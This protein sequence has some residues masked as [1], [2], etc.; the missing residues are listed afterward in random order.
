M[1][2]YTSPLTLSSA[3]NIYSFKNSPTSV[4]Q[5]DKKYRA[6]AR[7]YHPDKLSG[8]WGGELSE[9]NSGEE[10][11]LVKESYGIIKGYILNGDVSNE[12]SRIESFDACM[13]SALLSAVAKKDSNTC[14]AL[15][16]RLANDTLDTGVP[17]K[18]KKRRRE[19]LRIRRERRKG[20]IERWGGEGKVECFFGGGVRK[21]ERSVF[22]D[23]WNLGR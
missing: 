16:S 6:L 20:R 13:L 14:G 21:S 7:K 18:V 5:L 15:G 2:K 1:S 3:L 12:D 17:L 11:V 4:K 9:F 8:G 19:F 22:L 23:N 10:F